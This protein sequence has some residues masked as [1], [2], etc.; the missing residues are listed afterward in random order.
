MVSGRDEEFHRDDI[1]HTCKCQDTVDM[2]GLH[3]VFDWT[4][5]VS[6]EKEQDE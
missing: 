5:R 1:L 4:E 6:K 2:M 3:C